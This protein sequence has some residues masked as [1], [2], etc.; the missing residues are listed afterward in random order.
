M[1]F[2]RNWTLSS[3]LLLSNAGFGYHFAEVT[4]ESFMQGMDQLFTGY[5]ANPN[6]ETRY[7]TGLSHLASGLIDHP[8]IKAIVSTFERKKTGS[9][10][11]LYGSEG[12][13]ND[14]SQASCEH[15]LD[16]ISDGFRSDFGLDKHKNYHINAGFF[17]L[18]PY[19]KMT[20]HNHKDS[21]GVMVIIK[22]E[23]RSLNFDIV[24]SPE[25]SKVTIQKTKDMWLREGEVSSFGI[26]RDNLHELY[27][28]D[29]GVIFLSIY[30]HPGHVF[31]YGVPE[32]ELVQSET[33]VIRNKKEFYD[34]GW[35][36]AW[37]YPY[38][39]II[40]H[41]ESDTVTLLPFNADVKEEL[42]SQE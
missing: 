24:S 13:N 21:N 9:K 8:E 39:K 23:L 36:Q 1:N 22:G 33:P 20:L 28:G 12:N 34:A 14:D 31:N 35:K 30:T 4:P 18:P 26:A 41:D 32:G 7:L 25:L 37:D 3:L 42:P 11:E 5:S 29:E 10:C 15:I 16:E 17:Y 40:Y 27:S 19:T 38:R 6:M 2:I